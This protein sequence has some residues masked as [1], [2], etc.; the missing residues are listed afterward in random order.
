MEN[1]LISASDVSE[2]AQNSLDKVHSTG[3]R[4]YTEFEVLPENSV[5]LWANSRCILGVGRFHS[6][7]KSNTRV[8]PILTKDKIK[9]TKDA[10][11][12]FCAF[13]VQ[14]D[15]KEDMKLYLKEDMTEQTSRNASLL[16]SE[17][18]KELTN[19]EFMIYDE[20]THSKVNFMDNVI[21]SKIR[22]HFNQDS[23]EEI[24]TKIAAGDGDLWSRFSRH[25]KGRI[26]LD[27]V[28]N[29]IEG[30]R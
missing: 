17:T 10:G 15:S 20:V 22:I 16:E 29:Y 21:H 24:F 8:N 30:L 18:K 12:S 2:P 5:Y 7:E 27:N 9:N 19:N 23:L 26:S 4:L 6:G 14:C 3:F 11:K 1:S 28:L 13:F 25:D